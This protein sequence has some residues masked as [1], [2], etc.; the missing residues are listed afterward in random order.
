MANA[1]DWD[2]DEVERARIKADL[3]PLKNISKRN[4][5]QTK[6]QDVGTNLENENEKLVKNVNDLKKKNK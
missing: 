5:N 3:Q 1:N 2:V 6:L 4:N